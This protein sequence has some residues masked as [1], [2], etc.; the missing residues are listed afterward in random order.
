MQLSI[1]NILYALHLLIVESI[2][3]KKGIM[4]SNVL[5]VNFSSFL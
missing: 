5:Q 3:K 4:D 1:L 2:K